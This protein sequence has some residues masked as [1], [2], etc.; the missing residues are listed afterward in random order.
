MFIDLCNVNHMV[1][2]SLLQHDDSVLNMQGQ[3]NIKM[4]PGDGSFGLDT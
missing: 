3:S 4:M 1:S 2:G